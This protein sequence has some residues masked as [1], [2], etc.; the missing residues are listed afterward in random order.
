ME[1]APEVQATLG[2]WHT[3]T[4][5]E[6]PDEEHRWKKYLEKH[7]HRERSWHVG[8]TFKYLP[9]KYA[10]TMVE[11]GEVK[12][13]PLSNFRDTVGY[14]ESI[15]D[16]DEGEALIRLQN[17]S[18]TE[19]G[20]FTNRGR[21]P[22]A[23]EWLE[24]TG[25]AK[26]SPEATGIHIGE[27]ITNRRAP[28][29]YVYCMSREGSRRMLTRY[30]G[31]QCKEHDPIDTIVRVE[32]PIPFL[33]RVTVQLAEQEEVRQPIARH[34]YYLENRTVDYYQRD[35]S[36]ILKNLPFVKDEATYGW[37]KEVRAIWP[38]LDEPEGP[39]IEQYDGVSELCTIEQTLTDGEKAEIKA[40]KK[41][42]SN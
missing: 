2:N 38:A 21:D 35:S 4:I 5:I 7:L 9:Y 27:V 12:I 32:E 3:P 15:A 37:Q 18:Q 33:N 10:R 31:K 29:V 17:I 22:E 16:A 25:V 34:C 40:H 20:F 13:T 8:P 26:I 11:H 23:R 41:E 1:S 24:E 42:K 39:I 6:S 30:Y 28:P 19:A 36:E 14:G